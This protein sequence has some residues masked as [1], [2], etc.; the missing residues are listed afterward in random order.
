LCP[1]GILVITI[2]RGHVFCLQLHRGNQRITIADYE[3]AET[4]P[5]AADEA[6]PPDL[7]PRT[8]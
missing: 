8:P 7:T 5:G 4:T 6:P 2:A 3:G 1:D